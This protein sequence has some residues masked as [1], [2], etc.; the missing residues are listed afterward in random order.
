MK[1][2]EEKAKKIA[3]KSSSILILGEIGSGKEMFAQS[4]HN[5][6]SRKDQP[7]LSQNCAA[8]PEALLDEILFGTAKLEES[9]AGSRQNN[10]TERAGLIERAFGGTLLLDQISAMSFTL[11]T[12]L[13]RALQD[14]QIKRVGGQT[15][16]AIDLRVIATTNKPLEKLAEQGRFRK[17]LLY[18]LSEDS[19]SMPPLRE[20]GDDILL[21]AMDFVEKECKSQGIEKKTIS[22]DAKK[23]LLSYPYFGNIR[24]L[25]NV[26]AAAIA[27]AETS[28]K[29]EEKHIRFL[30]QS[31][32]GSNVEQSQLQGA[33][34][35]EK[36]ETIE[37][38]IINTTLRETGG[39]ITHA[40]KKLGISRQA[41]QYKV[42]QM[43]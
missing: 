29:I 33:T 18:R 23:K 10:I 16:I 37:N 14:K 30:Q 31:Q 36:M 28:E 25:E 4:I 38:S 13:L 5:A 20:R 11:Q 12:K 2:A 15:N 42:R 8:L 21:L 9:L 35:K 40:A 41:L 7:F 27:L 43:K 19:L 24:E 26:I 34:L 1:A 39:N 22:E 17:D 3:K 6:S 32:D